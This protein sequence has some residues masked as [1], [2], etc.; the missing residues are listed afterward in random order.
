MKFGFLTVYWRDM[1]RFFRFRALLVTSLIQPAIWLG[2]F[3]IAMTS[4]FARFSTAI[5]LPPGVFLVSYLTFIAAGMIA[6]T[7]LFTS[8]FGGITLLFDKNWGMMREVLASP[9]P[10]NDIIIGMGLSGVTKSFIQVLILAGFAM[11]LGAQFFVNYTPLEIAVAVFGILLFVAL[12]SLGFV[13]L[14]SAIAVTMESPES[15]QAVIT[16][17]SLP[18][19]F[20][21]N[22]LYP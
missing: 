2:L 19:F 22:A 17:L 4:I 3:G 11:L 10:R 12:F 20:T 15:L 13:F 1:L 21:S 16:L 14:S 6:M 9:I 7:T 8:L 18:I 5:P